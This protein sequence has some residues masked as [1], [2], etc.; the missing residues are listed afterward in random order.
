[1]EYGC[2]N[3]RWIYELTCLFFSGN[4]MGDAGARLLAKALQI[5]CRI[6]SIQYDRNNITLQGYC[7]LAYA[8]ERYLYHRLYRH[9]MRFVLG[10]INCILLVC[11]NYTVRYM[12]V[13]LM[14]ILPCMKLSAEKTDCV[15]RRIQDILHRNVS[16]KKYSNGQAFR[17]QQ[18]CRYDLALF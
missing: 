8:L 16:P 5:N 6:R 2:F 13:P 3:Q 10:S 18:V 17:L 11:S 9:R 4:L 7:D 14:D 1:M 15:M 12:P